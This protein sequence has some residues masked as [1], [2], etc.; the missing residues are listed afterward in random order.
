[1]TASR[2]PDNIAHGLPTAARAWP[3]DAMDCP[4]KPRPSSQMPRPA[5]ECPGP[6]WGA[7]AQPRAA[8]AGTDAKGQ[9]QK[10]RDTTKTRCQP[11]MPRAGHR[12]Q[13][14]ATEAKG[15]PQQPGASHTSAC[16]T[17]GAIFLRPRARYAP[18]P[19]SQGFL[20]TASLRTEFKTPPTSSEMAINMG[21]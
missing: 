18:V 12:C 9:S 6:S 1:M 19:R 10:P 14:P 16:H 13:G 20:Q 4:Q 3:P 5:H 15:Q 7:K 11:Q 21:S 8:R 17:L 2:S